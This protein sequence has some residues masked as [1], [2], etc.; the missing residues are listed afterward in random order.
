MLNA[1]IGST[2]FIAPAERIYGQPEVPSSKYYTL[3]YVLAA[4]LA[5]GTSRVIF[6]AQSDDSEALFRGCRALGAELTWEDEQQRTLLVRGIGGQT[7]V[8]APVTI[9][10]GNAG[11]VSRLLLGVGALLPE[12]TFVTDHPESLGK[13]PNR[14]LLE[15]LTS[16]GVECEGTGSEGCFPITLHRSQL[17][18]GRVQ[19]SGARSSQYLSALLFLGPLLDEG[20]DITVVDG[21][22][23][24]P[25]V[26]ASLDVLQTAG[27]VVEYDET[28]LHFVIPGKQQYQAREY[29]IPGDYPSAATLLAL[30]AASNDPQSEIRLE[31]LRSGEEVGEALLQAFVAMGADLQRDADTIT[32]RGG[33]RLRGYELD[34]DAVID[35]IPVLV[36]AAC[37]AE[38]ETRFFNIESLHYKESDR[39]EDLCRELRKAGCAVM[40]QSDAIVVQGRPQGVEGGVIVD[41][42]HDHRV[43]MAL[44]IVGMR[45]RSGLTLTGA[46]HIAKSYPHF[47]E[48][49][50]RLGVPVRY[51]D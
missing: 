45:S 37:F 36:A 19:I 32:L 13:R 12:V 6:P 14:E 15:A 47:F 2:L 30:C 18:G 35:C 27:I 42:H 8:N 46:E 16:L 40:P 38:G 28:F 44:A 39:I 17:H 1:N 7:P 23:S 31:R 34:G 22:K 43:L 4:A 29:V 26:R 20:L 41:G 50:Q 21:L 49:L 48:E 10:V 51:R 9:N 25:L 5:R 11:A 3:R 24:Q 33:R